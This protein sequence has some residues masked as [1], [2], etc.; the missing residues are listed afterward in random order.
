M[1]TTEQIDVLS[2]S[3]HG[4]VV[5]SSY[6]HEQYCNC[7]LTRKSSK[8]KPFS[9]AVSFSVYACMRSYHVYV[10]YIRVSG[11][12]FESNRMGQFEV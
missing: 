1:Y 6:Y 11:M 9:S 7:K 2:F 5:A 4:T 10:F 12:K 3:R 8:Q